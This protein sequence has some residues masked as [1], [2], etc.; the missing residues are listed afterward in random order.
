[1]TYWTDP[2]SDPKP[3]YRGPER[4]LAKDETEL[5][6]LIAACK[7]GR[8]YDVE[9]WIAAG[10][11]LQVDP[12]SRTRTSRA[13]SILQVAIATGSY[14]LVRLLLCN[15]YELALE[16]HPPLNSVLED[17]RWDLL[18]LLS[19][20]ARTRRKPTCGGSWTPT[21]GRCSS[22]SGPRASI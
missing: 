10:K 8:F 3:P 11:P 13:A 9:K 1:M 14:D 16:P 15:G 20:G 5:T 19:T 17:R 21:S 6:E 18:A 12:G 7:E 2:R 22:G 4:P